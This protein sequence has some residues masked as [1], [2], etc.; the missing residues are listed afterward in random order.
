MVRLLRY[1]VPSGAAVA[2][3]EQD[4]IL[5]PERGAPRAAGWPG[6]A[7]TLGAFAAAAVVVVLRDPAAVLHPQLWAEDGMFWFANAY[8]HGPVAP[9]LHAHTGYLQTFPR[10]VADL[11]LLVPL[12][13]LPLLFAIVAIAVQSAPVG[14][15]ASARCEDVVGRRPVRLAVAAL[16]LAVPNS[17]EVASNLTNAQWHLALLAFL[18]L[19]AAPGGRAWKAFDVAVL[20]LSGLTGPFAIILAPLGLVWLRR[21]R[22]CRWTAVLW[23]IAALAAALQCVE[24]VVSPRGHYAA[25]G[26]S[27]SR[28]V[29]IVG[30]QVGIG[31]LFGEH[32]I[33][34][35]Q[36]HAPHLAFAADVLGLAG[37]LGL[38]G[39][40]LAKGPL[41]LRLFVAFAVAIVAAALASPVTSLTHPQWAQLALPDDGQRYWFL[42]TLAVLVSLLWLGSSLL[43]RRRAH[44]PVAMRGPVLRMAAAGPLAALAL[45]APFGM[46]L[47]WKVPTYPAVGFRQAA[48]RFVSARPGSPLDV[49]IEPPGWHMVLVKH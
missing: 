48:Q 42:P 17:W 5:A 30:G 6:A 32:G 47:D 4:R 27:A 43:A 7:L 12:P 2:A 21:G 8:D 11:G 15:L 41:A 19:V 22:R 36:A 46:R 33:A 10:L 29:A 45:S 28:L 16:Y 34:W 38:L 40:A 31:P 26:A 23:L 49:P 25:L 44:D 24:L 39:A 35:L 13:A 20:T 9:L 18:C 3:S 37:V 14:L 1:G